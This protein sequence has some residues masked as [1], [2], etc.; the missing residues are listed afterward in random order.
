MLGPD[1]LIAP[2]PYPEAPDAYTIEFPSHDWYD[3][4]T[5]VKVTPPAVAA[6]T[7][8]QLLAPRHSPSRCSLNWLSSP[9]T[10]APDRSCPWNR[11]CKAQAKYRM[12][13]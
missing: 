3:Y 6:D 12:V 8:L 5:G 2:S 7:S 4:W 13:R 11:W 1:L 9:S 10:F